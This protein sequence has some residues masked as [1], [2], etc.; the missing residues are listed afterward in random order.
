MTQKHPS[1]FTN[2]SQN[3]HIYLL[4]LRHRQG[5]SLDMFQFISVTMVWSQKSSL[6]KKWILSV[7]MVCLLTD[8]LKNNHPLKI[9]LRGLRAKRLPQKDE[10]AKNISELLAQAALHAPPGVAFA[11]RSWPL[12]LPSFSLSLLFSLRLLL[13]TH[14]RESPVCENLFPPIFWH[15]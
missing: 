9:K 13:F 11:M 1:I 3:V 14:F 8:T 12:L 7:L 4:K 15:N 5:A 6:G 2:I 10:T